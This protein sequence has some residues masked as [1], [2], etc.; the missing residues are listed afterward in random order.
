MS[1]AIITGGGAGMGL[2]VAKALVADGWQV[3]LLDV[4]N[5][6]GEAAAQTLGRSQCHFFRADVT[7][8]DELRE[9]FEA[10]FS[11]LR[12]I[13]FVFANAGIA[14]RADF[15]DRVEAE[16]SAWPPQ[17]PSLL[18]EEICLRGV[19]FTSHLAMHYMRRNPTPGG[20]IVS[21]ASGM[22]TSLPFFPS[23]FSNQKMLT[24]SRVHIRI[25]RIAA[26]HGGQA[27]H[28]GPHA[29]LE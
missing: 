17:Q 2:A 12:R 24:L 1:V 25:R 4:N 22:F 26:L 29:V 21:T 6:V 27:R 3:A 19:I 14:G 15:Y 16:T 8:Y 23:F 9:A 5:E 11:S 13:D 28:S 18:V 20:V 10:V 7:K